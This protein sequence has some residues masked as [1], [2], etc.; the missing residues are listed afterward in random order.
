MNPNYPIS[1]EASEV[2]GITEDQVRDLEKF[3]YF[4]SDILYIFEGAAI[5]GF[6][7]D[8]FDIPMLYK[9]FARVGINWDLSNVNLV[10]ISK[11]YTRLF[12]RTLQAIHKRYFG[13]A[14]DNAHD[15]MADTDATR[16]IFFKMLG[17]GIIR[18]D[19]GET[20]SGFDDLALFANF[21]KKKAD[22]G[23]KF[24]YNEYDEICFAFG[25]YQ[26]EVVGS[27]PNHHGFLNWMLKNDFMADAKEI[28]KRFL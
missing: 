20:V 27:N 3:D 17:S 15:A 6:R 7:S 8:Y 23:G 5:S 10:D 22:I 28:A 11:L 26:N 24:Y 18:E 1:Q 16:A 19:T 2:H 21:E 14:F 4:A 12:P 25:K 13:V 9:E